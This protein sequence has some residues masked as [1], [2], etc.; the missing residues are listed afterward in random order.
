M[1][2]NVI[3]VDELGNEYGS[4]YPKRAKKLVKQGRAR[5]L[6]ENRLCLVRD[7]LACPPNHGLEDNVMSE[8]VTE[9][10]EKVENITAEC[11]GTESNAE[12][13]K[14]SIEYCLEQIEQIAHQTEHVTQAISELRQI[15][16]GGA[17]DS[18]GQAKAAA[19]SD[20]VKCRETT[21]QQLLQFYEKMYDDLKTPV[22]V[23]AMTQKARLQEQLFKVMGNTIVAAG[24]NADD[25]TDM[26]NSAFDAIRHI[27][28]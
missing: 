8:Q 17:N 10:I 28:D 19:L 22:T 4:T 13:N 2:K 15:E 5:F 3:V 9:N 7:C 12:T 6:T 20:V 14:Y 27:N 18:T 11:N 24:C 16:H 21:N 1:T 26:F 25:L 23:D